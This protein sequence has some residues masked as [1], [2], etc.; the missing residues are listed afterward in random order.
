MGLNSIFDETA[1]FSGLFEN[2]QHQRISDVKHKAFLDVNE[3]GSEAAAAT[4]KNF[5]YFLFFIFFVLNYFIFL[6]SYEN[7][8]H[9][10][11]FRSESIPC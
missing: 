8:T 9:E 6:F 1:N 3:A 4:C 5:F 11:E 2:A 10:L 7:C